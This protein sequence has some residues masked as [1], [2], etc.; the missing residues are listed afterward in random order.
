MPLSASTPRNLQAGALSADIENGQRNLWKQEMIRNLNQL[1]ISGGLTQFQNE[2]YLLQLQEERQVDI[3]QQM[4]NIKSLNQS[5]NKEVQS[6]Q[7]SIEDDLELD[8]FENIICST[9]PALLSKDYNTRLEL[10]K[11]CQINLNQVLMR[12]SRRLQNLKAEQINIQGLKKRER[13]NLEY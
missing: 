5:I 8:N 9:D 12:K 11:S 2:G 1:S 10:M 3:Q 13:G 4:A 6:N 7:G